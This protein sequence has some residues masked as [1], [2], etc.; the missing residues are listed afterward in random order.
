VRGGGGRTGAGWRGSHLGLRGWVV[1]THS[2]TGRRGEMR[3]MFK[4]YDRRAFLRERAR[5][6][7]TGAADK[8]SICRFPF[9]PHLR[10][11][12]RIAIVHV[13]GFAAVAGGRAWRGGGPT[14]PAVASLL[15]AGRWR[16]SS[17]STPLF[18]CSL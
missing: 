13:F 18:G 4:A 10:V 17:R 1:E 12:S 6:R 5:P 15:I 9:A 11:I 14:G 16:L 3:L 8:H 2:A 7:G